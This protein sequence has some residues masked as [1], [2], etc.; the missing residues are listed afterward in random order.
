MQ[1]SHLNATPMGNS[2]YHVTP[3][4]TLGEENCPMSPNQGHMRPACKAGDPNP[5]SDPMLA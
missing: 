1:Q 5:N 4:H 3:V 2:S